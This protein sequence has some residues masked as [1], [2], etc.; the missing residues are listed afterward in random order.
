MR[1]LTTLSII[2][3]GDKVLLAM[4]K[5]GFGAGWWNGFGGKPNQNESIEDAAIRELQEESGVVA[6]KQ[7]ERAVIEFYF[8]GTDNIIEMH[9]FEVTE[10]EGEPVET[11]EMAPRWFTKA[12]APYDQMW[13]ADREW[14]PLFFAGKDFTGVATFDGETKTF[15]SAKFQEV[16]KL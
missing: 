7:R 13:P 8:Q 5:R 1:Q 9:V 2:E 11:E 3:D 15:I 12:E 16:A 14:M 6:K 10:Y 4:K